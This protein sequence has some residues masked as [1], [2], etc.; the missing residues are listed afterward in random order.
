[1]NN[2]AALRSALDEIIKFNNYVNE[3]NYVQEFYSRMCEKLMRKKGLSDYKNVFDKYDSNRDDLLSKDDLQKMM[4]ES[5][6]RNV[7]HAEASFTFNIL[8][9]FKPTMNART[10]ENWAASF[11]GLGQKRLIQYSQYLDVATMRM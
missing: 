6:M 8:S 11:E 10:F 7:T 1:M 9:K 5:G 2:E 3:F 4:L